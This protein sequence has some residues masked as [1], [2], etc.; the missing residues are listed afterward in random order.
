LDV[1]FH[2]FAVCEVRPG[3]RLV[4]DPMDAVVIHYVLAGAG[5]LQTDAG[6]AVPFGT[7]S[8]IIV[9]PGKHQSLARPSGPLRDA[10]AAENCSPA[11]DGLV[12]FDAGSGEGEILTICATITATY[13]GG[14]GLFDS[15]VEPIVENIASLEQVRDAFRIMLA[16][17]AKPGIGTRALTEALMKQCMILLLRKHLE[18]Q[19]P[20]SPVFAV[21]KDARL[22]RAVA[23]I[24]GH[25]SAPYGLSELAEIAGMSRSSFADRFSEAFGQSPLEFLQ[26]VR[27]RHAAH[28]LGATDLPVKVVASSVGYAS[29][30]HFSRTFRDTYGVDPTTYRLENALTEAPLSL[31]SRAE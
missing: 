9:P 15:L 24:V 10:P 13:G 30:S 21:L 2:A 11:A 27:L 18:H 1:R 23:A 3:W 17:I 31:V 28:L 6:V 19:G 16:E 7:H 29:R 12:K 14:F 22:A 25:P 20:A 26:K 8:I 4:F 5:A